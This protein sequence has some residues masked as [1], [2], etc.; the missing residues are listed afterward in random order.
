MTAEHVVYVEDWFV[1]LASNALQILLSRSLEINNYLETQGNFDRARDSKEY[2]AAFL[3]VIANVP[4]PAEIG[5]WVQPVDHVIILGDEGYT[6]LLLTA[7][8]KA[9]GWNDTVVD[10]MCIHTPTFA[11]RGAALEGRKK[12][13]SH[14]DSRKPRKW[15]EDERDWVAVEKVINGDEL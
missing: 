12:R 4:P 9:I 13:R 11:A 10:G 2:Q 14:D 7:V 15:D 5:S 8:K 1:G 3:D 6:D